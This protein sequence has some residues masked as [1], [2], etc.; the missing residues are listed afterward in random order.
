M[1]TLLPRAG[2]ERTILL[3]TPLRLS[4]PPPPTSKKLLLLGSNSAQYKGYVRVS[5]AVCMGAG[6]VGLVDDV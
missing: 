4:P 5:F 2:S 1:L 3:P 6:I